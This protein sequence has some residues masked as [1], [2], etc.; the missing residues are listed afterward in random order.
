[1]VVE[2]PMTFSWEE[3]TSELIVRTTPEGGNP[4]V[5]D[6]ATMIAHARAFG[7]V[8]M[9]SAV[10]DVTPT[11]KEEFLVY[12]ATKSL[13]NLKSLEKSPGSPVQPST[14]SGNAPETSRTQ[15]SD[16]K[17]RCTGM[18][19]NGSGQ[20]KIEDEK[21]EVDL[22]GKPFCVH[23]HDQGNWASP[24][25]ARPAISPDLDLS[26]SATKYLEEAL[27]RCGFDRT[28]AGDL[29]DFAQSGY[30][31]PSD[32][33]GVLRRIL[34]SESTPPGVVNSDNLY[35]VPLGDYPVRSGR[36]VY[37]SWY[38]WDGEIRFRQSIARRADSKGRHYDLISRPVRVLLDKLIKLFPE[39]DESTPMWWSIDVRERLVLRLLDVDEVGAAFKVVPLSNSSSTADDNSKG[40]VK[41]SGSK[42]SPDDGSRSASKKLKGAKV[43]TS[44]SKSNKAPAKTPPPAAS[45]TRKTKGAKSAPTKITKGSNTIM[46]VDDILNVAETRVR[47][48]ASASVEVYKFFT[49]WRV[50]PDQLRKDAVLAGV[51]KRQKKDVLAFIKK[52]EAEEGEE[53]GGNV[54]SKLAKAVAKLATGDK[55][56]KDL[57][58]KAIDEL[59]AKGFDGKAID[60]ALEAL[61]KKEG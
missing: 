17:P 38:S 24:P 31:S 7:I 37:P 48:D 41:T 5:P 40:K 11:V 58:T 21:L 16:P 2:D 8:T 45:G 12:V 43:K 47:A 6:K 29:A 15:T 32:F 28:E 52:F 59:L 25:P 26:G 34:S 35:R 30:N 60:K 36:H 39:Y 54:D 18:R 27:V 9:N 42:P 4:A 10:M 23:H 51:P 13:L 3:L 61:N 1:M 44:G 53:T 57:K 22:D 49:A 56:K 33:K 50:A 14:A 19:T 20:C 46:D 55:G